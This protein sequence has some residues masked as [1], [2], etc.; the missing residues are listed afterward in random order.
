MKRFVL[1]SILFLA[2]ILTFGCMG[3]GETTQTTDRGVSGA[4]TPSE[5]APAPSTPN[6]GSGT[7]TQTV[8]QTKEGSITLKV[9]E[10][11]LE[12][13]LADVKAM[14]ANNGATIQDIRYYESDSRKEYD[15]T[16]KVD[17]S[18]FDAI[19]SK[20]ADYGAVKD[21]SV[22]IADVTKQYQDLDTQINN[23]KI[24]LD[25]LT[26]LYNRTD[27]ISDLLDIEREIT[28]VETN[29]D[30]LKGE[31]QYLVSRIEKATI[32]IVIYE[33]KP[34]STQLTLPLEGIGGL[35]FG[36]LG[37][38]LTLLVL[39]AGFLVPIAIVIWIIWWV[40]KKIRGD[41]GSRPRKSAHSQIPPPQSG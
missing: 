19:T 17:P 35:F 34:A 2:L 6:A 32:T 16:I 40:Y 31:K 29:L 37:A 23:S 39:A 11:T 13:K 22:S 14:L 27:N 3:I 25:R 26:S 18:K 9:P 24:E 38:A 33:D 30:M 12:M 15:V 1:I 21:L 41:G 4:L 10:A 36:A 28:R 5:S 7:S 8:Y 20:L